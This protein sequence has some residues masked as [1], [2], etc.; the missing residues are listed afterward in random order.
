MTEGH[1]LLNKPVK[2]QLKAALAVVVPLFLLS[3]VSMVLSLRNLDKTLREQYTN[4]AIASA[5][6]FEIILGEYLDLSQVVAFVSNIGQLKLALP[7]IQGAHLYAVRNGQL[8]PIYSTDKRLTNPS[9]LYQ[10]YNEVISQGNPV[11]WE[12][13]RDNEPVLSVLT[14]IRFGGRTPQPIALEIVLELKHLNQEIQR[15]ALQ[16]AAFSLL[17]LLVT[18]GFAAWAINHWVIRRIVRLS[19]QV[20]AFGQG[21]PTQ[22]AAMVDPVADEVGELS[23]AF[24]R[25]RYDLRSTH[26]KL[27]QSEKLSAVGQLAGGVAHEINNP[28]GVIMG[29]AESALGCVG[30]GDPL[31]MPLQSIQR[32][33]MRCK[34]LVQDLLTFSRV[35]R[36]ELEQIDLNEAIESTLSLFRGQAKMGQFEI[37]KELALHL[38]RVLGNP[39]QIQQIVVN[40]A[41]NAF[42]AMGRQGT[43]AVKTSLLSDN[44]RTWICLAVSDTG[45]GIPPEAM[46]RIF[47]PFFTT[48]PVGKGTGLGLGLVHEIIQK[49][50]GTIDVQ[51][52]PGFTEF[53]IKF[54]VLTDQERE[55]RIAEYQMRSLAN[56][57]KEGRAAND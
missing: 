57:P 8:T 11:S 19:E 49:H 38:P 39:N 9:L 6:F 51:S 43:L 42:D 37:R 32:E 52:R 46:P 34:N 33:A 35:S 55:E 22:T 45:S 1:W 27:L 16:Q 18:M 24:E 28:L 36:V 40:L 13:R 3:V 50:S 48:K 47:E 41:N 44:D 14:P 5:R 54:P 20:V 21:T 17:G 2:L 29:F 23:R 15:F 10:N 25:M 53:C 31:E 30:K 7:H 12:S 26:L 4:R 56:P